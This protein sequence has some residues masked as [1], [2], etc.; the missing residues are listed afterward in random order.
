[1]RSVTWNFEQPDGSSL[2]AQLADRLAGD[3][4]INALPPRAVAMRMIHQLLLVG[5]RDEPLDRTVAA[6]HLVVL[7]DSSEEELA[8]WAQTRH[9]NRIEEWFR[10]TEQRLNIVEE[11][12][13]KLVHPNE[14]A[15]DALAARHRSWVTADT[16]TFRMLGIDKAVEISQAWS[17]PARIDAK[18]FD[19]CLL[20]EADSRHL[21]VVGSAGAGKSILLQKLAHHATTSGSIVLNVRLPELLECKRDD[22]AIG[23]ALARLLADNAGFSK[24]DARRIVRSAE[25]VFA[26]GLDECENEALTLLDDLVSYAANL[27]TLRLVVS[28]RTHF[29]SRI[30][31]ELL[32]AH[33]LPLDS[34]QVTDTIGRLLLS[35][36]EPD[37]AV[38][39]A[40]AGVSL[41]TDDTRLELTSLNV[42][43]MLHLARNHQGKQL[44][45]AELYAAVLDSLRTRP[46]LGRSRSPED[47]VL[48]ARTLAVAGWILCR[49][50][51]RSL[52]DLVAEVSALIAGRSQEDRSRVESALALWERLAVTRRIRIHGVDRLE[53]VHDTLR[54]FA[55]SEHVVRL[56]AT[57]RSAWF[58][59]FAH[60]FPTIC[61]FV[62]EI[63]GPRALNELL[64]ATDD[65][66]VENAELRA[67]ALFACPSVDATAVRRIVDTIGRALASARPVITQRVA[68]ECVPLV[69]LAPEEFARICMSCLQGP[70]EW[71]V[72]AAIRLL[73]ALP[74]ELIPLDQILDLMEQRVFDTAHRPGATVKVVT[75]LLWNDLVVPT[76]EILVKH[77]PSPRLDALVKELAHDGKGISAATSMS[78]SLRLEAWGYENLREEQR[79]AWRNRTTRPSW[80]RRAWEGDVAFLN[81]VCQTFEGTPAAAATNE[82]LP[83][84]GR[85]VAALEYGDAH[86]GEW[87]RHFFLESGDAVQAVVTGVAHAAELDP[88]QLAAE[89]AYALRNRVPESFPDHILYMPLS[90]LSV[91]SPREL[92]WSRCAALALDV[93]DLFQLLRSRSTV[94]ARNACHLLLHHA[95]RD[96]VATRAEAE[97]R[98]PRGYVALLLGEV[99][100]ELF[101]PRA[102][103]VLRSILATRL[104]P[105]TAPLLPFLVAL[106]ANTPDTRS[107][108]LKYL[109]TDQ[110]A[111]VKSATEAALL[112]SPFPVDE[113]RGALTRF[114][115]GAVPATFQFCGMPSFSSAVANKL[116]TAIADHEGFSL[117]ELAE[118]KNHVWIRTAA[119]R[120]LVTVAARST[121]TFADLLRDINTGR[122]TWDLLMDILE[123]PHESLKPHAEQLLA[124][125]QHEEESVRAALMDA[126]GAATWVT[127]EVATRTIRLHLDDPAAEVRSAADRALGRE[128]SSKLDRATRRARLQQ[129]GARRST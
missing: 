53:F 86:P 85:L 107:L 106:D 72:L 78:I 68:V 70:D 117:T 90:E 10:R 91:P 3:P 23:V 16:R 31:T 120:K 5:S 123:L 65:L 113:M 103:D 96:T 37:E 69:H 67:A 93:D 63:G 71:N 88:G 24:E 26:D 41:A 124:L 7:F 21:V 82:D 4:R 81:L 28:T 9:A 30:P 34:S 1:L 49:H 129:T 33:L 128:L 119:D 89:A 99:S 14:E 83:A 126:L 39:H 87:S 6:A 48:A 44:S 102:K 38:A 122:L 17:V 92:A 76:L 54:D 32:V 27:P 47:R 51:D 114:L 35:I 108:V 95:H 2:F 59:E 73:V 56:T 66:N 22:V 101:G 75:W 11:T 12:I 74:D 98:N 20:L 42:V 45:R 18:Q 61:S 104:T 64:D 77:R 94:L 116:F 50:P 55:A 80:D 43:M 115:D 52:H 110:P 58:S 111:V 84:L 112:L 62:V 109:H 118:L 125:H 121:E 79:A 60:R 46:V 29:E 57:D 36:G 97:L 15:D 105:E 127:K 100:E 19:A 40:R 8:A 25:V 13:E